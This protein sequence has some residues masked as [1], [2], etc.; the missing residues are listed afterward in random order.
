V[1]RGCMDVRAKILSEATRLFAEKGVDGTSLQEISDAVGVR[2][3]S[4]LYHFPSKEALHASVL[5]DL[6][7]R[8]NEAVPRLL[9]AA[10]REDRF[11]A[12]LDETFS[13]FAADPDRARLLLR[14]A[15]D[16]PAEMRALLRVHVAAWLG[17]VAD[18]IRKA[19]ADGSMLD[20]VDPEAWVLQV[21]QLVVGNFA[22][23]AILQVLLNGERAPR[24]PSRLVDSRMIRELK[25]VARASLVDRT[26]GRAH[27]RHPDAG[28][29]PMQ[30]RPRTARSK[31]ALR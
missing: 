17:V 1:E 22:V 8:W 6:L 21:I 20:E 28:S 31:G 27:E 24:S 9:R 7:S 11:D 29:E 19:Q 26:H 3:P 12:V 5:E 23:G 4:L 2:K 14:E 25:R 30:S 15:L 18:S 13:F 10:A 16:R